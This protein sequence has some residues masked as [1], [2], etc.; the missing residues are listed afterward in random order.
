MEAFVSETLEAD[1]ASTY[2]PVFTNPSGAKANTRQ[3]SDAG[4]ISV[5]G[6]QMASLL[7]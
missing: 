6:W 4:G 5:G 2:A 7:F 1:S 3:C